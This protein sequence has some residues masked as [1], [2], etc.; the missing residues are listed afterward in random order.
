MINFL[1][2]SS[3]LFT[4]FPQH[5]HNEISLNVKLICTI[6]LSNTFYSAI[7]VDKK[8][9][10]LGS[11]ADS[12]LSRWASNR[13]CGGNGIHSNSVGP[14]SQAWRQ[15]RSLNS[16]NPACGS[17]HISSVLMSSTTCWALRIEHPYCSAG[18]YEPLHIPSLLITEWLHLDCT[19]CCQPL[20]NCFLVAHRKCFEN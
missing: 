5:K 15:A 8:V 7:H 3:E 11:V 17:F 2:A 9:K 13:W 12:A 20:V 1:Y 16:R 4:C 6:Y 14:I 18:I 10:C 19:A